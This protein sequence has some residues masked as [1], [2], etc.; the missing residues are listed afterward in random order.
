VALKAVLTTESPLPASGAETR[1][2]FH[3]E[4]GLPLVRQ[5]VKRG[6]NDEIEK[7]TSIDRLGDW[8]DDLLVEKKLKRRRIGFY[9]LRH[10]FP[11]WADETNDQH[12]IH[13]IMG[14]SIP[15]M[16]GIY[17]EEIDL[18]RRRR[19]VNHVRRKLWP[20]AGDTASPPPNRG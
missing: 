13:V 1:V 11:T 2:V 14:H 19:V 9:T 6:I 17:V 7:V 16:S 10:T 4:S 15:G 20:N 3:S 5:I 8:F 18:K 12:A